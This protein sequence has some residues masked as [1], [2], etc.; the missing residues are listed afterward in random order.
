LIY[1]RRG[2]ETISRSDRRRVCVFGVDLARHEQRQRERRALSTR[3]AAIGSRREKVVSARRLADHKLQILR[4]EV[5]FVDKSLNLLPNLFEIARPAWV[6][7][8]DRPT[9]IALRRAHLAA[10]RERDRRSHQAHQCLGGSH[11]RMA[12]LPAS[13]RCQRYRQ[14]RQPD[15]AH[16]VAV[17]IDGRYEMRVGLALDRRQ[18]CRHPTRGI[19]AEIKSD[20]LR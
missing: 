18:G 3:P 10:C 1:R 5:A 11:L 13:I 7:F 19:R 17:A 14:I 20:Y 6:T 9:G 16:L 4:Q 8:L 2:K 12:K 15:A